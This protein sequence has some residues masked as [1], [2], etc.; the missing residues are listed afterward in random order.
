MIL[1]L[2]TI[3]SIAVCSGHVAYAQEASATEVAFKEY[4]IKAAFLFNFAKFVEW[5]YKAFP[6]E[7]SPLV[8]GVLGEDPF[9]HVLEE[10]V[11]NQTI[12]GRKLVIKRFRR[13][14]ELK[15]CHILFISPSE[16]KAV[17]EILASLKNRHILTV[18][19]IDRFAARGGIICFVQQNSSIHFE[20]NVEAAKTAELKISSKLL[21][22]AQVVDSI[23]FSGDSPE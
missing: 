23:S 18:S 19:D 16:K 15:I 11:E 5:P 21:R 17:P 13:I 20:I 9:G 6:N 4:Q 3:V 10:L 1:G 12:N 22:L 7:I 2:F 14:E 8:I